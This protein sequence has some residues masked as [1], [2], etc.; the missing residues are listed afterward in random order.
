MWYLWS[1]SCHRQRLPSSTGYH[2]TLGTQLGI[3]LT[4][5]NGILCLW[6]I[7]LVT[8]SME[9]FCFSCAHLRPSSQ[10]MPFSFP[11]ISILVCFPSLYTIY[12]NIHHRANALPSRTKGLFSTWRP[13]LPTVWGSVCSDAPSGCLDVDFRSITFSITLIIKLSQFCFLLS[14]FI[15]ATRFGLPSAFQNLPIQFY[16][17]NHP[18]VRVM[19]WSFCL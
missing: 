2:S 12:F 6:F 5:S 11:C 4:E 19:F 15:L 16:P 9:D 8:S 17:S 10:T 14:D 1:K 13:E 3:Y 7:Y 18:L